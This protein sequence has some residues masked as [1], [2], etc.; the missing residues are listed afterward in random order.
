MAQDC[1]GKG[2]KNAFS[3][4][5]Q[6]FQTKHASTQIMIIAEVDSPVHSILGKI[7]MVVPR[8]S[9]QLE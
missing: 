9:I 6:N 7:D 5:K 4:F 1:C 8:P 3:N 2:L